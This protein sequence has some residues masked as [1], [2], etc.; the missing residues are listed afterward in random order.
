MQHRADVE[1]ARRAADADPVAFELLFA[2]TID[3]VHAYA[4]A[5]APSVEAAER[6]SERALECVFRSLHRYEGRVSLSAWVLAIVKRELRCDASVSRHPE[7]STV[8]AA[9]FG[10]AS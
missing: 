9:R 3:R 10:S 6:V 4:L 2:D 5:R 1:R 8:L 7:A